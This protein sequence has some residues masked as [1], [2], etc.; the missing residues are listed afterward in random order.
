MNVKASR[1]AF[2][3]LIRVWA[4]PGL[5]EQV[6]EEI[7]PF[8]KATQAPQQF[9]VP[10]L[11]R[12]EIDL[13]GLIES[14]PLFKACYYECLRLDSAALAIRSVKK[15]FTLTGTPTSVSRGEHSAGYLLEAG[16]FVAIPLNAHLKDPRYIDRPCDFE[17][18]RFLVPNGKSDGA[19][20]ADA[21]VL[22]PFGGG[23]FLCPEAV[24]AER[25]IMALVAG[26][27]VL[28]DMEPT[29]PK[30]W[31]VPGHIASMGVA[32]PSTNVR[33][34]VR[35]RKLPSWLEVASSIDVVC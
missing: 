14:C 12:L 5:V 2:W 6:R 16:T 30:G 15:D 23:E 10:E 11:P 21:G 8:A 26:I 35:R 19:L 3:L 25:E 7:A 9:A 29:K 20:I 4:K 28:W 31:V 13:K 24:F 17:P 18:S 32:S 33:V 22:R 34:R 1:I 27:V